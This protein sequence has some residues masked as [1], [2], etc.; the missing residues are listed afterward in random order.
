MSRVI[1]CMPQ[2]SNR[3]KKAVHGLC[4]F[5]HGLLQVWISLA[6]SNH[7]LIHR[8]CN[9]R[10]QMGHRQL[11]VAWWIRNY[12]HF[13][14]GRYEANGANVHSCQS[15]RVCFRFLW[16]VICLA[17]SITCLLLSTPYTFRVQIANFSTCK[18]G[19]PQKNVPANRYTF[20][21]DYL[22]VYVRCDRYI[23]YIIFRK[24]LSHH[25]HG[26]NIVIYPFCH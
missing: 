4:S 20:P 7:L 8:E 24:L 3:Y 5:C 11:W 21:A 19:N 18:Y 15:S 26:W 13:K 14:N 23:I 2:R 17:C 25:N 6:L 22:C 9:C 12:E 16:P 1:K 10:N